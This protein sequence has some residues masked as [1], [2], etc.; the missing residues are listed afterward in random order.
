MRKKSTVRL[1]LDPNLREEFESAVTTVGRELTADHDAQIVLRDQSGSP[2]QA[3]TVRVCNL[4][5]SGPD[6]SEALS[7]PDA[8]AWFGSSTPVD[9]NQ[10]DF[11][12]RCL[13]RAR[14][15]PLEYRVG[16][17]GQVERHEPRPAEKRNALSAF[18]QFAER[19]GV[20]SA[21]AEDLS[22]ALDE[23]LLGSLPDGPSHP[24]STGVSPELVFACNEFE[25][26]ISLRQPKGAIDRDSVLALIRRGSAGLQQ[27][28]QDVDGLGLTRILQC[29]TTLSLGASDDQ[30]VELTIVR[31]RGQR[32][33]AFLQSAP[34]LVLSLP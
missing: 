10:F 31:R 2:G 32:R 27:G 18:A 5:G 9:F 17:R 28:G 30:S 8:S 15:D 16:P 6:A 33:R 26:G 13:E 12:L 23:M 3:G 24:S 14:I 34:A 21:I 20:H 22:S 29:A 4:R 25:V 19:A 7:D 1:D 11:V